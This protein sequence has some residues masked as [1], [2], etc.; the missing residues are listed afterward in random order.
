MVQFSKEAAK[1]IAKVVRQVEQSPVKRGYS[2]ATRKG[3]G[4]NGK[5]VRYNGE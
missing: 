5:W 1:R 3:K 2:V 4:N